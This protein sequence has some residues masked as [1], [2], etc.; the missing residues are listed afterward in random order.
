[1][2]L[3]GVI[4]SCRTVAGTDFHN[5]GYR[6]GMYLSCEGGNWSLVQLNCLQRL[7]RYL[8]GCYSNTH[9]NT[10]V[11]Q[12]ASIGASNLD[13]AFLDRMHSCWQRR[14]TAPFPI[15]RMRTF[16]PPCIT[17]PAPSL[18]SFNE[19]LKTIVNTFLQNPPP[20]HAISSFQSYASYYP[21]R[22]QGQSIFNGADFY[23]RHG[24]MHHS[25]VAL[26][27]APLVR[28]YKNLGD[29]RA[30]ALTNREIEMLTIAALFHDYG[31][32]QVGNDL[33]GDT[34]EMERIGAD[35]CFYYL[36]AHYGATD[37]EA[38]KIRQA[39]IGK[40]HALASKTIYQEIL[41]NA[42]CLAVLR[43][44][45]WNFDVRYSNLHTRI[46]SSF[47]AG[48][49]ADHHRTFEQLIAANK[50]FLVAVG[51][52]P[53]DLTTSTGELIQGNFNLATKRSYERSPNCFALLQQVYVQHVTM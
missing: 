32:L 25:H 20:A 9:L 41:Q 12:A 34:A 44:D 38:E 33:G 3:I 48:Q 28:L 37:E 22:Y 26:L 45:D 8:F 19:H 31:R 49:K 46:E 50:R 5:L 39:C 1:M 7:L 13:P 36:R 23:V 17:L 51:D 29:V 30:Q 4:N 53:Y 42:D 21:H 40:D 10:I 35:A 2:S 18:V 11:R 52:S 24:A 6:S 16:S 27:I 43:A 14:N 47:F 15:L